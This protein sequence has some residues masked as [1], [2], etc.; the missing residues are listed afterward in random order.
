L[1]DADLADPK[2]AE[3]TLDPAFNGTVRHLAEARPGLAV[4]F[5]CGDPEAPDENGGVVGTGMLARPFTAE[6]L[7]GTLGRAL[8]EASA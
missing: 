3:A 2:L 1:A 5:A 7:R 4:L 8:A 6:D